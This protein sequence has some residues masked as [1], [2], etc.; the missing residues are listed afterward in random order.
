MDKP[1]YFAA[2][3]TIFGTH[4]QL[5][6]WSW[7]WRPSPRPNGARAVSAR[8]AL[9]L[10]KPAGTARKL[11]IGLIGPREAT[12]EELVAA[13]AIGAGLAD[14]GL[15]LI[16]GGKSGVMEAGAKGCLEAGGLTIGL[17]PDHDWRAA[18]PFIALPIATGLS[19]ARNMIIAKSCEVLIA[20][21]GS[22]GTITEVA[23][24]LHFS[25]PVLGLP[26]APEV[27][28]LE[29]VDGPEAALS[30]AADHLLY[31]VQVS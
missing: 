2:G 23:Y 24:G 10:L 1:E 21:G 12:P 27:A 31:R 14:M 7:V 8:A 4:G 3:D 30:R 15:T 25:K 20:I 29:T 9:M 18:N 5:D 28:G 26:G 13:Q 16:C 17:V 11:P 22:Y 6:P 19:E